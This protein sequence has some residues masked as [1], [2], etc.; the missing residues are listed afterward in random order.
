MQTNNENDKVILETAINSYVGYSLGEGNY[1]KKIELIKEVDSNL[2]KIKIS[3]VNNTNQ[4]RFILINSTTGEVVGHQGQGVKLGYVEDRIHDYT[5]KGVTQVDLSNYDQLPYYKIP[6]AIKLL[7]A[8]DTITAELK[9]KLEKKW[10]EYV[11]A[12]WNDYLCNKES[13]LKENIIDQQSESIEI[14]YKVVHDRSAYW[15]G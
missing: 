12:K 5:L 15:Y 13:T 11:N 6:L 10:D 3:G 8:K 1:V 14:S 2:Y 4:T 7:Q 9:E